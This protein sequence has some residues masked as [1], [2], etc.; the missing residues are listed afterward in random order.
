MF[1]PFFLLRR[2]A[3][4]EPGATM[5]KPLDLRGLRCPL[6]VLKTR[7]VLL[8]LV[9]GETLEVLSDDPLAALDIPNLLRETG[10][11]LV[12]SEPDG[13]GMRFLMRRA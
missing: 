13:A 12:L 7:K 9:A 10:D 3:A 6:P 8:S 2:G 1:A 4:S 5:I 11:E